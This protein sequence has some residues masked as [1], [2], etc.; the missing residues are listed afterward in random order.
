MYFHFSAIEHTHK[1]GIQKWF[2][3]VL[4]IYVCLL[5]F[6]NIAAIEGYVTCCLV[7][8]LSPKRGGGGLVT[9]L[10]ELYRYVRPQ[11]V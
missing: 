4:A 1:Y 2:S 6:C 7:Y 10:Y 8:I 11:R 5:F 3:N 9:S